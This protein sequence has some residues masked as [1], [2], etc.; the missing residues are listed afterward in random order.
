VT[1]VA[2]HAPRVRSWP[3]AVLVAVLVLWLPTLVPLWLGPLQGL[4]HGVVA[5]YLRT[6]PVLPGVLLPVLLHAQ[7]AWFWFEGAIATMTVFLVF[8]LAMRELPRPW[9]IALQAAVAGGVLAEA[10]VFAY[11]LTE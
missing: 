2:V 3:R 1:A 4:S 9:S 6:V 10:M 5:D 8:S 7:G 11:L